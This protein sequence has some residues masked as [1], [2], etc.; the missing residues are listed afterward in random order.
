MDLVPI[1]ALLAKFS[2]LLLILERQSVFKVF[3]G[4]L[5][6]QNRDKVEDMISG[7]L[8]LSQRRSA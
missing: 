1:R 6:I 8:Q 4:R 7:E 2:A 3:G 5:G